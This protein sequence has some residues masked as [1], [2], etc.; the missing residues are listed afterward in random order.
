MPGKTLRRRDRITRVYLMHR[1]AAFRILVIVVVAAVLGKILHFVIFKPEPYRSMAEKQH[2]IEVKVS[3]KR[4]TI[5]DRMGRP[6]AFSGEGLTLEIVDTISVKDSIKLSRWGI[7]VSRTAL[8]RRIEGLPPF[9]WDSLRGIRGIFRTL[10]NNR[11]YYPCGEACEDIV[12]RVRGIHG[13]SGIEYGYDSVLVPRYTVR[14][15]LKDASGKVYPMPVSL[16]TAIRHLLFGEDIS[17]GQDLH[18]TIDMNVQRIAYTLLKE[19]VERVDARGGMVVVADARTGDI[20]AYSSV[21]SLR[22]NHIFNYEPGSNFKIVVYTEG[23]ERGIKPEDTCGISD[24]VLNLG[25]GVQIRDITPLKDKTTWYWALVKS[26]NA[27]AAKLA[28][29]MDSLRKNGLYRR[30]L[31]YGFGEPADIG[32]PEDPVRFE[33]LSKYRMWRRVKIANMAIG[34]GIYVNPIQMVRAYIIVAN[35]G[36][37]IFPKLIQGPP[38]Y[39][40]IRTVAD[41]STFQTLKRLL[42]GVVDSGTGRWARIKGIKVAGKTGTAQ[43]Y[44]PKARRYSMARSL[45]SFIGFFPAET[46]KYVIYVLLDEPKKVRTGGT[47][48]APLFRKVALAIV[49]L[50]SL[51]GKFTY[52]R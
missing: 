47:A 13:V 40:P 50:D 26:S 4:G 17:D 48:A 36:K 44:D 34:Q 39:Y 18:T 37:F 25:G 22:R 6:L 8:H 15:Y 21:G 27:C 23:F 30:A 49:K 41:K 38:R 11:R 20:L 24:G 3:G 16:F 14:R 43:K 46:P 42:V 5:Y 29:M 19:R 12:G 1:L 2:V 33:K 28:L 45:T 9:L 51:Y 7:N 35:D 31:L 10:R 52:S 32:L